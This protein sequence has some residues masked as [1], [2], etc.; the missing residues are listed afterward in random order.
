MKLEPQI[1]FMH[2]SPK[3]PPGSASLNLSFDSV[4][5]ASCFL[6]S[7]GGV[8]FH[9]NMSS[10]EENGTTFGTGHADKISESCFSSYYQHIFRDFTI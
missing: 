9:A 4:S 3:D 6:L 10:S 5:G 1:S 7:T 2:T 8:A